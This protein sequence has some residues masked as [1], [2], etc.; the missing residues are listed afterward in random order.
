M[1]LCWPLRV[2]Y[3]N[4]CRESGDPLLDLGGVITASGEQEND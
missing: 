3:S 2:P 4:W 1:A